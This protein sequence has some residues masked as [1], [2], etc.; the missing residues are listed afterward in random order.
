MQYNCHSNIGFIV[1]IPHA[2]SP[3][4]ENTELVVGRQEVE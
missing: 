4:Q 2:K 3:E 1:Y